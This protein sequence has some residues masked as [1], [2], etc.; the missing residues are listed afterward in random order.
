MAGTNRLEW[1]SECPTCPSGA[2]ECEPLLQGA[3]RTA[4]AMHVN[5]NCSTEASL[6]SYVWLQMSDENT[7]SSDTN[8]RIAILQCTTE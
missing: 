7:S 4:E 8:G 5:L 6:V 3:D 1:S 2:N